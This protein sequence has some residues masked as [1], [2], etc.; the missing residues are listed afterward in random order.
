MKLTQFEEPSVDLKYRGVTYSKGAVK[1]IEPKVE[2]TKT[3][4]THLEM[5]P[6]KQSL[7]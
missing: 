4:V 6:E 3:L 1:L 7:A 5:L 2:P